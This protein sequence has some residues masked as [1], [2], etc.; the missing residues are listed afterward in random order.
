MSL[1]PIRYQQQGFSFVPLDEPGWVIAHQ[2]P[3]LIVLGRY[4][5]EPDDLSMIQ[6]GVMAGDG[7]KSFDSLV[8]DLRRGMSPEV[9]FG[10]ESNSVEAAPAVGEKCARSH[11]VAKNAQARVIEVW[12]LLCPN[13]SDA[14]SALNLTY[15]TRYREGARDPQSDANA[16]KILDSFEL[17]RAQP[18]GG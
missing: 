12:M 14:R 1:P 3:E 16:G 11:T 15:M 6:A 17:T 7:E 2:E 18:G 13:P 5:S 8:D 10:V 4:G 9:G